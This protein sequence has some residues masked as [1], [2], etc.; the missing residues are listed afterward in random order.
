MRFTLFLLTLHYFRAMSALQQQKAVWGLDT[1][2]NSLNALTTTSNKTQERLRMEAAERNRQSRLRAIQEANARAAAGFAK[3]SEDMSKKHK[4]ARGE[5]VD[6]VKRRKKANAAAT[7]I[8]GAWKAFLARRAFRK[9]V[10]K[11]REIVARQAIVQV[12]V[13]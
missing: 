1:L 11:S 10:L 5:L 13:L 6:G 12:R 8:Q 9:W 2:P 4:L 3:R 7:K